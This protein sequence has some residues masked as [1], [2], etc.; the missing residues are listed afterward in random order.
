ML[1]A[2]RSVAALALAPRFEASVVRWQKLVWSL[3]RLR[4]K[5]RCW[6]LLGQLLQTYPATLR[7]RLLSIYT[8]AR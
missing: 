8:K 4:F 3:H 5:Q 2:L 1:E 6:G 7:E